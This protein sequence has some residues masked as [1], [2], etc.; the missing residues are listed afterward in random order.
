MI[1]MYN[2]WT[3][4]DRTRSFRALLADAIKSMKKKLQFD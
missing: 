3:L 4:I 2:K 1:A